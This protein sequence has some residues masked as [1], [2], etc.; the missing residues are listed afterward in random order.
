VQAA[1]SSSSFLLFVQYLFFAR[2]RSEGAARLPPVLP[3]V[4]D[5]YLEWFK[6]NRSSHPP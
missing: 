6:T 1:T 2:L 4:P 3:S 5:V